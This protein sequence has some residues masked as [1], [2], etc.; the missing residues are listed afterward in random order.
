MRQTIELLQIK[1]IPWSE[2]TTFGSSGLIALDII[3]V[4]W[5]YV[6]LLI[7]TRKFRKNDLRLHL[8]LHILLKIVSNA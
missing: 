8:I 7:S 4:V 5:F 6:L 3:L 1:N 2:L